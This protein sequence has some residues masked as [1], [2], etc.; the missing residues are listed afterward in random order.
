MIDVTL[1]G[2]NNT[3]SS[4]GDNNGYIASVGNIEEE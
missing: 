1:L 3:E 2:Q 4:A